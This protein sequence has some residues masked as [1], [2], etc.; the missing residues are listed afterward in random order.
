MGSL[1]AVYICL[2]RRPKMCH[3]VASYAIEEFAETRI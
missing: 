2:G 3:C 1:V